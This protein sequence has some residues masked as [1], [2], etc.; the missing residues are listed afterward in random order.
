MFLKPGDKVSMRDLISG[1]LVASGNDAAVAVAIHLA[2]TQEA[3]V[4][5]MN[6]EAARLGLVN[7]HFSNVMGLPSPAHYSSSYDL[8]RLAYHIMT[9]FPEYLDWFGQKNISYNGID[10]QNY[11]KL[12][13]RYQY[14]IGLKTGSTEES[15]FALVSAAKKPDQETQLIGVVMGAST[16]DLSVTASQ[17][18]L[19]YGFRFFKTQRLY[20]ADHVMGHP[21]VY[22]AKNKEV[23]VGLGKPLDVTFPNIDSTLLQSQMVLKDSLRAPI[24]E[25]EPVGILQVKLQDKLLA[26]EPIIALSSDEE[27]SWWQRLRD[28]VSLM[29]GMK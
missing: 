1:I 18:L 15:G 20:A 16:R 28:R 8:A 24:R 21:R 17:A 2:G 25:K 19:N 27:G 22:M 12:L 3:F 7:T 5:M 4:A 26:Q 6:Q 11:N 29:F 13:F 10:Q 9:D 23:P 14:A